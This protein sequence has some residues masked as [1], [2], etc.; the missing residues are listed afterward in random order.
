MGPSHFR[1]IILA[2]IVVASSAPGL[3]AHAAGVVTFGMTS[4]TATSIP[5]FIAED[6][7]FYSAEGLEVETIVAGSTAGVLHQLA[8]G[9]LNMAQA[10]TDQTLRAIVRGAPIRIIAG[11]TSK[12]E[13]RMVAAKGTRSWAELKGKTISVGGPTDVTLYFLRVMA[14]KNGL[15]DHD[16]DVIY[17]GSTPNRFAQLLSGA[18]GGAILT[19]PQ[20]F[21]ALEQGF[22]DLG[23][24]PRYLPRWAQNNLLVDTRWA[25]AHRAEVIAFLRAYIRATRYLYDPANRADIIAIF[26]QYTRASREITALTYDLYVRDQVVALDAALFVDGIAANIEALVAMGEFATPPALADCIDSSFLAD[27]ARK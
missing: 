27:V 23:R 5:Y 18:V 13:F 10:A 15:A 16:Y 8:A 2:L 1:K 4:T 21:M 9:S 19:N 24:V 20:D 3:P 7:K 6:K 22:V 14:R 25:V 12:A 26:A 11:A 17:S